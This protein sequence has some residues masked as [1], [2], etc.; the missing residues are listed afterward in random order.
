[1]GEKKNRAFDYS[2]YENWRKPEELIP[3][4]KNAK[5]HD[6]K[7]I[8]N[9][10]NSIKRF[11]WQQEAVITSDGVLV[12]GHGRRL[13]AIE[14]GCDMPVKIIDKE[15]D[16][17]TD[18][19]IKELRIADNKTNESEWDIDLLTEDMEGLDFEGFDLEFGGLIPESKNT[20]ETEPVQSKVDELPESTVYICSV[21][22][23]GTNSESILEIVLDQETAN[24]VLETIREGTGTQGITT[25]LRE[26]LNGL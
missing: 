26:A 6:K 4:A 16:E 15:A 19:D 14:L 24:K 12:I 21:S 20:E 25:R 11:G 7:Q 18:K 22:A 23:F 13:A 10:A 2:H 9:I 17:L 3:Y 5:V 8:K 1:M